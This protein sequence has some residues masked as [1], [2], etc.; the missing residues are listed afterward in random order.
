MLNLEAVT[1]YHITDD[2]TGA[3]ER[4]VYRA[5]VFAS[6]K[7]RAEDGGFVCG[8]SAKIRIPGKAAISVAV[9]DYVFIGEGPT[10]LDTGACYKVIGICDRRKGGLP[11]WIIEAV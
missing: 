1:V 4:V 8:D 7:Q 3:Y 5:H 10:S 9:H 2:E 6:D 11:H